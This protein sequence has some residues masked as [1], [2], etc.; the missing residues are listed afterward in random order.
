MTTTTTMTTMTIGDTF[1]HAT[2]SPDTIGKRV[3]G[4]R[5][6]PT[7]VT[8]HRMSVMLSQLL[9]VH[10]AAVYV[11]A[12]CQCLADTFDVQTVATLAVLKH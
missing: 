12:K 8:T 7:A 9:D 11:Q 3:P 10:V 2:G 6:K 1:A 4:I 5:R